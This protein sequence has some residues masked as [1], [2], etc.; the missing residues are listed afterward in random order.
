[1]PGKLKHSRQAV[2]DAINHTNQ[3][4]DDPLTLER[5]ALGY[6]QD[7]TEPGANKNTRL[8]VYA[9]NGSGL[10]GTQNVTYDRLSFTRYFLN[11]TVFVFGEPVQKA[12]DVL[13]LVNDKYQTEI[14]KED[15]IDIDVSGLGEDW[16]VEIQPKPGNVM[17][18]GSFRLRYARHIPTLEELIVNNVV[19]VLKAPY[20]LGDKPRAEFLSYA[21]DYTEMSAM[22]DAMVVGATVTEVQVEAMNVA[23]NLNFD[24]AIPAE[25]PSGAVGL[26]GAKVK[27]VRVTVTE[28]SKYNPIYQKVAVITLAATSN[29]AGDLFLHYAPVE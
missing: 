24:T 8:L 15:I 28:D 19:D 16:I 21:Y 5:I 6:A 22:L 25:L 3:L 23:A 27:A 17:W 26:Y 18:T 1:M 9:L 10:R 14:R 7:I 11:I 29:Y 2:V 20:Q 4:W 12:S 13:H